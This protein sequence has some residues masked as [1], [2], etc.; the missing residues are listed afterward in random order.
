MTRSLADS[1]IDLLI[2]LAESGEIDPWDVKVIEV[3]D[4]FLS[5][6]QPERSPEQLNTAGRAPYEADLS[7]SGQAF[8][9]ASVL[10][11]LKADSLA[12]LEAEQEMEVVE[13]VE[14]AEINALPRNLERRIRRRAVAPAAPNRRVT[15]QELIAQLNLISS[16]MTDQK[17]RRV[18]LRRPRP[19][20]QKQAI[21][22]I[23]QLAHQENLLEVA[24]SL[25]QFLNQY[26]ENLDQQQNW[27][28][29]EVLL[30][31]WTAT[32]IPPQTDAA[33]EPTAGPTVHDRVGAF[34]ALLFLS[35]QSKV[36]LAQEEFYQ[37]LQVRSLADLLKTEAANAE[38]NKGNA[39]PNAA[40][41]LASEHLALLD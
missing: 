21:R 29:F 34:W 20:S 32:Q 9:Y 24:A 15:L 7:E 10:L 5:K 16:A 27:L 33:V 30:Q 31:L 3:I 17:P 18:P 36:E 40:L 13:E 22:A 8:L 6:L 12:R 38:I 41:A 23:A 4:R 14:L 2:E 35:A 1:A 11:L 28:D 26:W 37:D 19:Q 39:A 25:D